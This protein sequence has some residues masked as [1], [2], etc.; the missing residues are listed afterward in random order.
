MVENAEE[1]GSIFCVF[2]SLTYNFCQKITW[3][4][5]LQKTSKNSFHH[6]ILRFGMNPYVPFKAY[7][8]IPDHA[9][10]NIKV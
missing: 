2:T 7:L 8:Y 4:L 6:E 5:I 9:R 3:K 10:N 1:T